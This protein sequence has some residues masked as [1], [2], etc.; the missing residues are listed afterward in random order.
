M[1][2]KYNKYNAE[3]KCKLKA[4]SIRYA[5]LVK[6]TGYSRL[7]ILNWLRA[8]C[9]ASRLAIIEQAIEKIEEDRQNGLGHKYTIRTVL[10]TA[11]FTAVQFFYT[12]LCHLNTSLQQQRIPQGA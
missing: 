12:Y 2:G 10:C 8:P 6:A 11:A 5:D 7:T 4:R 3:L 1:T 9:D